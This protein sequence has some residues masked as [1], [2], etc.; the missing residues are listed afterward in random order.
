MNESKSNYKDIVILGGGTAGWLT[1][2]FLKQ[3]WK[4]LNVSVIEDPNRPPIIAGESGTTTFIGLLKHLKI[5]INDFIL[6]VNATPKLGGKFTDWN[7][8]GTEFIHSLQ[9]DYA[10]WLDG[11]TDYFNTNETEELKLGRLYDVM[12][13]ESAKDIYLKTIIANNIPLADAFYATYFVKQ[14]KVPFGHTT[15]ELPI[16]AMWHFESRATAAYLKELGLSRE[17]NLIEGVYTGVEQNDA[18][19]ITKLHLE[20]GRSI[21]G[22]WFFDCSGFSRLL[23]GGVLKEPVVDYTDYFPARSVVA[24]WDKPE[25]QVTTNAIAMKYGWSWNINL[26]HRSGNGYIFDPDHINLDQAI[27]EAETRFGKKIDPIANFTF[28]PG[29]MKNA[30]K[31]NVIAVGLSSGF[32]E[33]LEANG[34]QVIIET[35]YALQDHWDPSYILPSPGRRERVN[36][37]IWFITEHIRDFLALHYRGQRDDTD[38]WKSHKYDKFRVPAS[39]QEKL[40]DWQD[41]YQGNT[42][43]PVFHGYSPTAWLMVLQGLQ[44]FDYNN[45]AEQH[46]SVLDIG[47]KIINI[48]E[49]RYMSLS[50]PFWSID[51]WIEKTA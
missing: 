28:T 10:P 30:W 24:W 35:L 29:M 12:N 41:Y 20:D 4:D 3:N 9:T 19:D 18:G 37:R 51:E 14:N 44:V 5:D 13:Q 1:A 22:A 43:E 21:N 25:Y 34:V 48:N 11:W 46:R 27:Q 32:L 26:R 47:K 45:L 23:L 42:S 50:S 17:I 49:E 15:N 40:N 16:T 8:V 6:K 7:G 36:G 39:L 31:N 38:F 33:P 2:L